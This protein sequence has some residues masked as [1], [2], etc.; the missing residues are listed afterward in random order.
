MLPVSDA[1]VPGAGRMR[2]R[3]DLEV[4]GLAGRKQ[5]GHGLEVEGTPDARGDN[6]EQVLD[7]LVCDE[8]IGQLE[9]PPRVGCVSRRV[10]S[11]LLQPPDDPRNKKNDRDVD[12]ER[13]PVL[14]AAY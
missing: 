7:R 3:D 14:A 4:T 10:G 6:A 9:E 12:D 13:Q 5:Q 8:E 2:S 1:G 11:K